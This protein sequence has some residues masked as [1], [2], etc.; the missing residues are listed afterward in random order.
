MAG[1]FRVLL[2][3]SNIRFRRS[4]RAAICLRTELAEASAWARRWPLPALPHWGKEGG[5]IGVA[6][7]TRSAPASGLVAA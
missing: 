5:A 4:K 2:A 6:E 1:V 3:R 7:R